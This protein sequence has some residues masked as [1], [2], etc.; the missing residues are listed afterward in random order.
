MLDLPQS[1]FSEWLS[2]LSYCIYL[3]RIFSWFYVYYIRFLPHIGI[4]RL[5][6][7]FKS[8]IL[9]FILPVHPF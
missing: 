6:T 5:G 8:V 2:Q 3:E 4:K 9:K 1:L 7:G